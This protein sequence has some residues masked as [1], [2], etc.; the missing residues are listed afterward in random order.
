MRASHILF[1]TMDKSEE[2]AKKLEALAHEVLAKIKAGG[3]FAALAKQYSE[4]PGTKDKGGELGW[5]VRGQMV[6][7]FEQATFAL[8]PG[9][10]SDVVKTEYGFHII[11]VH[12][13]DRAHMQTF[14]EVKEQIRKEIQQQKEEEQRLGKMDEAVAV[15]RKFGADFE[16]AG[17]ELGVPV[18]TYGPFPRISP[19]A[20]LPT[21]PNF[22]SSLFSSPQGEVFTEAAG[23]ATMLLV[24]TEIQP[25][26]IPELEEVRAKVTEQWTLREAGELARKR[27]QEIADA[28]RQAGG[29]LKQAAAKFGLSTKT[30]EFV[31]RGD[32]IAD[33]GSAQMLGDAFSK[34][35]GT[36]GGPVSGGSDQTIYRVAAHQDAD[37]T[38]F[39]GQ[40]DKLREQ[41]VQAKRDEAYEIYKSMTRQRY[42]DAGKIKRYQPRIDALLQSLGRRT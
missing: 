18:E 19:P 34:E 27:A 24:V 16:A 17:K 41:Q 36:I 33:V 20:G 30:S 29:D 42:E 7:N 2:E 37:I 21:T 28:A 13:R 25:A 31:T 9:Q 3:D 39:Y 14:D 23:D 15:A 6:P 32:T 10:V 12:E 40:Q 5:I 38:K 26:R 1:M 22:L 11:K 4:D 35:P 8:E